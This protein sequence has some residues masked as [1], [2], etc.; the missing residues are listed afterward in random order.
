MVGWPGYSRHRLLG[1]EDASRREAV[2]MY[3]RNSMVGSELV[4]SCRNNQSDDNLFEVRKHAGVRCNA[5]P[6]GEELVRSPMAWLLHD[7]HS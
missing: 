1:F 2:F 5:G 7:S 4:N 6:L 3:A